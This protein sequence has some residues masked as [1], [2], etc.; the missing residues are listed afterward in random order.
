MCTIR[1][2]RTAAALSALACTLA[3]AALTASASAG[4]RDEERYYSSYGEPAV[5]SALA[6]ERYYSSYPEPE[7]R[8]APDAARGRDNTALLAALCMGSALVLVAGGLA[9]HHRKNRRQHTV[10]A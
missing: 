1:H 10:P 7:L 5:P 3:V 2:R 9:G 4:P 8:T 6:Q